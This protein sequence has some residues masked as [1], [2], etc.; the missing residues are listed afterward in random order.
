MSSG[1]GNSKKPSVDLSLSP[2]HNWQASW[3]ASQAQGTAVAMVVQDC[4][5]L[6]LRSPTTNVYKPKIPTLRHRSS[7]GSDDEE[8][9]LSELHGLKVE[10]VDR[11]HPD[12]MVQYA[13]SWL[14]IG[15]HSMCCM[16][17]LAMD[18]EHLCRVVQ[19]RVDDHYN[20]FQKSLTTHAVT[21]SLASTLQSV[22]LADGGRPYGIQALLV[23]C[24]GIEESGG[25]AALCIY[26][27]DP[28]GSWQSWGRATAIGRY[29]ADVRRILALKLR[30][31]H[32]PGEDGGEAT[33]IASGLEESVEC[34]LES[35]KETCLKQNVGKGD[36]R[37]N[38][39]YEVL[40]LQADP[41]NR[42]KS[43]LF[44]VPSKTISEMVQRVDA[45]LT[46]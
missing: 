7:D 10:M 8:T 11:E 44:R 25:S 22:C 9:V 15:S 19:K 31:P 18:V 16:T 33:A 17:G 43:L 26:S 34:L 28:S 2:I 27:I 20:V 23:G 6:F 13:P 40:I 39:D 35:W 21:Q 14:A 42:S 46:A 36:S 24:D 12:M 32:S 29:A 4:V 45:K 5:V 38:E 3:T 41:E 37:K 30:R 1:S